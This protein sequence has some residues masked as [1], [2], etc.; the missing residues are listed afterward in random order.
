MTAEQIRNARMILGESQHQFGLACNIE[1]ARLSA[2]ES[3]Y[4]SIRPEEIEHIR[5]HLEDSTAM[6]E[7]NARA[8]VARV[9]QVLENF[10]VAV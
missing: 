2:L 10:A 1:R 6:I 8:Q 7:S 5:K 4:K 3:G 9:H